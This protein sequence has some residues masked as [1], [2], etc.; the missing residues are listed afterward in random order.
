M[1]RT[2]AFDPFRGAEACPGPGVQSNQGKAEYIRNNT[3]SLYHPVGTCKMGDDPLGV[4]DSRLGVRGVEGLRVMDASIVPT[5]VGGRTQAVR[6]GV[7]TRHTLA[8]R[9]EAKRPNQTHRRY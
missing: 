7:T 9:G 2:R 3:E 6:G 8:E 4:V 1:A 5:I